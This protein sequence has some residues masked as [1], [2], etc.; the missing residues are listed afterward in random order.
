[1]VAASRTTASAWQRYAWAAGILFVGFFMAE[2][3]VS[4]GVGIN[5]N[6]SAVKIANALDDHRGRLL[7]ITYL[8]VVSSSPATRRSNGWRP[9]GGGSR[10]APRRLPSA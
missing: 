9:G 10:S 4:I 8:S 3:V 7:V 1:M 6:D 5:Q 2:T